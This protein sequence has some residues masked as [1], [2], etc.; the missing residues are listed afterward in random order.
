MSARS[1]I[2]LVWFVLILFGAIRAEAQIIESTNGNLRIKKFIQDSSETFASRYVK[3]GAIQNIKNSKFP[4]EIRFYSCSMSTNIVD[5][6][7]IQSTKDTA[8]INTKRIWFA[9]KVGIHNYTKVY[10]D[11]NFS[12]NVMTRP[13][14]VVKN[15]YHDLYKKLLTN[16]LFS[17]T[18]VQDSDEFI[19]N[20]SSI[21]DGN[22][23]HWIEIKVG[24]HFRNLTYFFSPRLNDPIESRQKKMREIINLVYNTLTFKY[25]EQK[26]QK[27]D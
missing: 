22:T 23:S 4:V 19:N 15:E 2:K 9:S 17:M 7:M 21:D 5:L 27:H 18:G 6:T 11:D 13:E 24:N 1:K 3:Y 26:L 14:K 16:G 10:A 12:V 20:G 8:I 25:N